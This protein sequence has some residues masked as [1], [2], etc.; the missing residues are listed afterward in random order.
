MDLKLRGK[1]FW[2]VDSHRFGIKEEKL[3]FGSYDL[4]LRGETLSDSHGFEVKS[5]G[6][7]VKGAKNSYLIFMDLKLRG[8]RYWMVMNLKLRRKNSIRY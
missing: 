6:F 4:K 7:E 3:Y 5:H 8:K 1:L 2:T